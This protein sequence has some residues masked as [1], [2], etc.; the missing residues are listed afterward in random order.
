M[1]EDQDDAAAKYFELAEQF[2]A[3]SDDEMDDATMPRRQQ[4]HRCSLT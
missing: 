3:L 4:L 1:E 2:L